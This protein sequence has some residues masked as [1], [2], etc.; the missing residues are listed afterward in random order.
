M[1][2]SAATLALMLVA[3]LAANPSSQKATESTKSVGTRITHYFPV[4]KEGITIKGEGSTKLSDVLREFTR[5][6]GQ[7]LVA[8]HNSEPL[9]EAVTTGLNQTVNV[10]AG[11]VYSFV[12]GLLAF[13]GFLV[14][15]LNT[16]EPRLLGIASA[17]GNDSGTLRTNAI[18]VPVEDI[19]AWNDHA[20][21]LIT[22][23]ITLPHT[24][25]R[26][27]SN[28]MRTLFS[29]ANTQQIVPVG[30]SNSLMILGRAPF[31]VSYVSMLQRCDEEARAQAE[32]EAANPDRQP[33]EPRPA[34]EKQKP[35]EAKKP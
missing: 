8:T 17:Q 24:D 14:Q 7:T 1:Q 27:L 18:Y 22:T 3:C 31:V 33:R 20:A 11:Q 15:P 2:L 13:H 32:A 35:A 12:E 5:V 4:P 23:M 10:P 26:T 30:N 29:D 25:V 6:T 34:Q 9:L 16:D 21:T 28:S 19:A